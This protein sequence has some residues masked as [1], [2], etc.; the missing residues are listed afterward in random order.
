M[1]TSYDSNEDLRADKTE[2]DEDL[3]QLND[4]GL[5]IRLDARRDISGIQTSR[6]CD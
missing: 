3:Y 4:I 1:E 5:A 6:S 2:V